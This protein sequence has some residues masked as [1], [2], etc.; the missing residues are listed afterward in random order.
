MKFKRED[1]F[2]VLFILMTALILISFKFDKQIV[3]FMSNFRVGLLTDFFLG[4]TFVSSNIIIFFFLTSLFLWNE[5][6]RR[7]IIP[8]WFILFLSVIISFFLKIMI[9][10]PRPFEIGL[11]VIQKALESMTMAGWNYS[12]PSFQTLLVFS[13]LP[14]LQKEFKKFKYIWLTFALLV[15]ISR[16]YFGIH[17]LSDVLAG[18]LIGYILG[19]FV[20]KLEEDKKF[21]E[22]INKSIYK[23]YERL[24]R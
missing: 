20:V 6:K 17:F 16:I 4:L 2:S 10:R 21:G 9:Q 11:P 1:V 7:W 13:A 19:L 15:G 24:K 22:K 3:S 23:N 12:F 14:I 18:A 8:L 5:Q